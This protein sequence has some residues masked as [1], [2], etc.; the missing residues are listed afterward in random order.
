MWVNWKRFSFGALML[1]SLSLLL[2]GCGDFSGKATG[3]KSVSGVVSDPATGLALPDA[4]VTA[5][6]ISASGVQSSVPL[7]SPASVQSDNKGRYRLQI[8][9]NYAGS[10]MI[11]ATKPASP[12]AKLAKLL[13]LPSAGDIL[14]RSAVPQNLVTR[15]SIPPVMVSFATNMV[16]QFLNSGV[17]TP[18]SADN[19]QKAIIVLE[20]YFGANFTQTPPPVSAA[21]SSTTKAQQDLIVSI[22]AIN[23][24]TLGS[25]AAAAAVAAALH[26]DGGIGPVADEIKTGIAAAISALSAQGILPAEYAPSAAINTAVSNAQFTKVLEPTLTDTVAPAA[27]AAL[28]A[29]GSSAKSVQLSWN[30]SA[31]ADVAGYLVYR[32]DA[33]GVYLCV[34]GV[35]A[36][37]GSFNDFTAAPATAYNYQVAAFDASRNLS[38]FSNTASVTTPAAAD[39]VQPSAPAGLVCKGFNHIQVNLQWLQST[40]TLSDGTIVPAVRYNVYRDA[41][42]VG[43]TTETSFIDFTVSPST[44]YSYYVKAADANANLSPASQT[45]T[46]RTSPA[47]GVVTPAA[48][49]GLG[50]T[51]ADLRFNNTPLVWSASASAA[52][53]SVT[54]NVYRDGQLI[55]T[56]ITATAYNDDSV[57]PNSNY[58]YAVTAV[59]AGIESLGGAPLSVA[60]PANPN[61]PDLVAPSVPGNLSVVSAASNSVALAWAPSSKT[62]GDRIVAGYDVLRGTGTGANYVKI[63]SVAQASFI[64]SSAVESTD[65]SYIVVSFSSAG[66][67]STPSLPA[68]VTT[69]AKIDLSDRTKPNAPTGLSSAAA[70]SDSVSLTW[71]VAT[72]S[73]ADAN[74]FVAGYLVYR[75]GAQIADAH[76][77]LSFTDSS[78]AAQTSYSYSV[79][80]YDNSGN[81][82]DLSPALTVVTPAAVPNSFTISGRVTLNG[83]GLF[84]VALTNGV[85]A[86]PVVTDV[87]GNYS[88]RGLAPGDYLITPTASPFYQFSP[89][90]RSVSIS[91]NLTGQDFSAVQTGNVI[92][93]VGY[94]TGTVIGG[95]SFPSGVV[96]GGVSYPA[97]TII[98]GVF[99]PT[100]TVIGGILYP[101][102]VVIGGVAYP[103]GTIV[104][105]VAFPIGAVTTGVT[106]P[107]GVVIG[108]VF[109][110]NGSVAGSVT[111]P[112]GVIIGGVTF[113]SGTVTGGVLYPTGGVLGGVAY[114]TGSTTAGVLY[115]SGALLAGT[116]YPT[117]S[118]SGAVTYG[119]ITLTGALDYRYVISGTVTDAADAPL[120]NATVLI[121]GTSY[122]VT[123]NL[124]GNY[125]LRVPAGSY[126][127][128]AALGGYLFQDS[129]PVTVN[130]ATQS[131][132]LTLKADPAAP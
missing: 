95:I 69:P 106:Y 96:I 89:V 127:L 48:P 120:A 113:P 53:Q 65:Y 86:N 5:Y 108:G 9:A 101:N 88:F 73:N 13:Q 44:S 70:T 35:A 104:G 117:G 15:A 60:I 29:T 98:G 8:P 58:L 49:A 62:T 6:A 90:R 115:P 79:R 97:G 59:A 122:Q 131:V 21:D 25:D 109:Y 14:I 125:L 10:I 110:P 22:R 72:K 76:N 52:T 47:P 36:A 130:E 1:A 93:G 50:L 28:A 19:I 128:R 51:L 42:F 92:G 102:G 77:L 114:P 123:S 132:T 4:K 67:R 74:H 24:F 2:F 23:S 27:P 11:E 80:A 17:S 112:S 85:S 61:L 107:S 116:S 78:V 68:A 38:A 84:G 99:Y 31:D 94:P 66:V 54:Y 103:S 121:P 111:Y 39:L 124:L 32:A 37:V 56:G 3:Q 75:D 87:N 63:A 26:Q 82:S 16:V 30:L 126:T 119:D 12:L 41:Q 20:T 34:G 43:F 83:V 46:V 55:A 18:L 81:L 105:G 45:L 118:A 33:S 64:D 91:A 7:S 129:A 100:G 57:A 40:K 71:N